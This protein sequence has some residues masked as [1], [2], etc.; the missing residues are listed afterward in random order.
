MDR[1]SAIKIYYYYICHYSKSNV[2]Q[3]FFLYNY[4]VA[5]VLLEIR[6]MYIIVMTFL[7]NPAKAACS[8]SI[9]APRL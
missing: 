3:R 2:S 5:I 1:V 9:S 7:S 6:N 8:P 4:H